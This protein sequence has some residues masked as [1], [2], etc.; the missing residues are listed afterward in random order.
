MHTFQLREEKRVVILDVHIPVAIKCRCCLRALVTQF[1]VLALE[2]H[3]ENAFEVS[4]GEA[5]VHLPFYH[6]LLLLLPQIPGIVVHLVHE[7]ELIQLSLSL[8]LL[9]L[10]VDALLSSLILLS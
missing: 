10:L 4:Q 5:L 6:Y 8:Q 7:K 1:K 3:V 2:V 9:Q